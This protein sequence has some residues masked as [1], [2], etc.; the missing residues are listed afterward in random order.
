M[1]ELIINYRDVSKSKKIINVTIGAYL[2]VFALYFTILEGIASR[3]GVLFF[4]A[5]AGFVLAAILILSN[6]IWVSGTSLVIDSNSIKPGLPGQN[7]TE[8]D[9]TSVSSV[10]IGVSYIVFSVNGGQKQRKLDLTA[11]VYDDVKSVK[12]KIIEVCEYK[13]ISYQ[14]D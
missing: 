9:W 6:T 3:Y 4:C 10:N 11:L 1:N 7:K 12:S 2:A 5:L 8:I 14:N 13:N